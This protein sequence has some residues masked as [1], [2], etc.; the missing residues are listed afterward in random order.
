MIKIPSKYI[1]NVRVMSRELTE[2]ESKLTDNFPVV[3]DD[4][5]YNF[6]TA[7]DEFTE[8]VI[9]ETPAKTP[10]REL[11][12]SATNEELQEFAKRVGLIKNKL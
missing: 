4:E 11:L 10:M 2:E 6:Y 7:E 9:E 3:I 1:D 12:N 5:N 8:P